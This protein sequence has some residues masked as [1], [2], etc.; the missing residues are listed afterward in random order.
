MTSLQ[1]LL[2]QAGSSTW[3]KTRAN[4]AGSE[5]D[6]IVV[7]HVVIRE[8]WLEKRPW[9]HA[10]YKIDVMSQ[11]SHWFVFKRYKEFYNLHQ[12][13]IKQYKIPK[14]LLPP[15]KITNNMAKETLENRRE[16]LEHYLQKLLN[17]CNTGVRRSEDL[18]EFLDVKSHDVPHVTHDLTRYICKHGQ[19][20]LLSKEMFRMSPSQLYCITKQLQ[21]PHP[22]GRNSVDLGYLYEFVSELKR[23]S[24]TDFISQMS[25][26]EQHEISFTFDLSIFTKLQ[27]LQMDAI[28]VESLKGVQSLNSKLVKLTARHCINSMKSILIDAAIEKR[29]APQVSHPGE[30]WRIQAAYRLAENRI[31]FQPWHT[32]THINFSHNNIISF[33]SSMSLLPALRQLDLSH[34]KLTHLDLDLVTAPIL[35]SLSLSN[36]SI[37]LISGSTKTIDN[38]RHLNLSHNKVNCLEG[39]FCCQGLEELNLTY[40]N[41]AAINEVTKLSSLSRLSNLL[42]EGNH[43]AKK[44]RHRIIIFAYFRERQLLLDKRPITQK[45]MAK[46]NSK[47]AALQRFEDID[48]SLSN[49]STVSDDSEPD[50]GYDHS[51]WVSKLAALSEIEESDYEVVPR[52]NWPEICNSGSNPVA[53]PDDNTD[54]ESIS[55]PNEMISREEWDR[56]LQ[57]E[58]KPLDLSLV[59]NLSHRSDETLKAST[60]RKTSATSNNDKTQQ[61]KLASSR[62][63]ENKTSPDKERT[64]SWLSNIF[65]KSSSIQEQSSCINPI[66][67]ILGPSGAISSHS[68]QPDGNINIQG[69][70]STL[71]NTPGAKN[72]SGLVVI[73]EVEETKASEVDPLARS[74]DDNAEFEKAEECDEGEEQ[75]DE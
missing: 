41:I 12:K 55:N 64:N 13:L 70:L 45:E 53:V 65:R 5:E 22:S 21:L 16:A 39:L 60:I 72:T 27:E 26:G 8:V 34:N 7:R 58:P 35:H 74:F 32:L 1:D 11:T 23:L 67:E 57:V 66:E 42:V 40:N 36:N 54:V 9:P 2:P 47:L 33:D 49:I 71:G 17:S 62:A 18:A 25:N 48:D 19:S 20:I 4:T 68:D 63:S 29:N 43:F 61:R 46:L 56:I 10:V 51:N 15:R 14:D 52:L 24:I 38:L 37:Y 44:K 59:Q 30:N 28:N 50:S 31:I 6:D 75:T 69:T 73:P 3:R